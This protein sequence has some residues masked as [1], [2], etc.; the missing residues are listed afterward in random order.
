MR[1]KVYGRHLGRN[2]NARTALF[3]NLVRSLFLHDS[4]ETTEA[5][6]KAIKGL[7]DTLITQ[8]KTPTSRLIVTQFLSNKEA[9]DRLVSEILPNVS[10]RTS[11]YTSM[12]KIGRRLGDG[13]MVVKMSIIKDEGGTKVSRVSKVESHD[14]IPSEVEG[15]PGRDYLLRDTSASLGMT[16][17]VRDDTWGVIG[18]LFLIYPLP[19]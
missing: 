12:V 18:F 6:A 13:T 15:S 9:S 17:K 4:I 8:A 14:V 5:K 11:G 2:R 10:N 3:K 16:G 7:I 19:D 1:H